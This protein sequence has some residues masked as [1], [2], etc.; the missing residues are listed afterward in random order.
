MGRPRLTL[1]YMTTT[2][3]DHPSTTTNHG[4]VRRA[5]ATAQAGLRTRRSE[6]AGRRTLERELAGYSSPADRLE[7]D[8]MLSRYEP[9]DV[10][11][12]QQL[13]LRTRA[14]A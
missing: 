2:H 7:L 1:V 14:A 3:H 8:A 11:D 5:W 9:S 12:I 6:R 10:R 4:P 13:V